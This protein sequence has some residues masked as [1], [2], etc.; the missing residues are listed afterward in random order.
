MTAVAIKSRL[1]EWLNEADLNY[2]QLADKAGVSVAAIRRLAKNQFG[3]IDP[4]TWKAV[5]DALG[6][7]INEMFWDDEDRSDA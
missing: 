2:T 5:C 6:K 3:R 4:G 1:Q 7:P